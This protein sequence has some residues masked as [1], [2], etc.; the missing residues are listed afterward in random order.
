MIKISKIETFKNNLENCENINLIIGPNNS[1]KTVFLH[2]IFRHASEVMVYNNAKWINRLFVKSENIRSLMENLVPKAFKVDN[3]ESIKDIRDTGYKLFNQKGNIWNQRVFSECNQLTEG[4]LDYEITKTSTR[5]NSKRHL[6]IFILSSLIVHEGCSNRLSGPFTT[7]ID[8]LL[9]DQK[10]NIL[11]YIFE[12]RKILYEINKNIKEVFGFEIGFDNLQQGNKHIRIIPKEKIAGKTYSHKTALE[13]QEKSSTI[14]Q[15]GDGIKAYMKLALSLLQP[16]K[17][18]IF[19]DEPETYLHP[20]QCRSL[21]NLVS[22][23]SKKE[24]KQLFV[25]THNTEFLRGVLSSGVSQIKIFYLKRDNNTFDYAIFNAKDI[26]KILKSKSNLINERILNSFFYKKTILCEDENDRIFYEHA[27]ALYLWDFFQDINFVGLNGMQQVQTI[28]WKLRQLDLEV[29]IIVDIDFLLGPFPSEIED[30]LLKQKFNTFKQSFNT[31]QDKRVLSKEN[32][33][34][35]GKDHIKNKQ[36][37]LLPDL[38]RIIEGFTNYSI[39][40]VPV[41][42]LESWT[43]NDIKGRNNIQNMLNVI[44]SKTKRSLKKFLKNILK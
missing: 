15:Q 17:S 43:R 22:T 4:E 5:G 44:Q 42:E 39:F 35:L 37:T 33:K 6:W 40:I 30:M 18:I 11:N 28:F 27:S 25:A 29:S 24:N 1:G 9:S 13:W 21:G 36:S 20:P 10:G 16:F 2:E 3:F 23:L 26:D 14:D 38:E 12:N 32:F 8:N 19:I 31:L 7:N 41:G 34:K